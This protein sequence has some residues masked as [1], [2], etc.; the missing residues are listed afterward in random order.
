VTPDNKISRIQEL[1]YEIRIGE[2][3]KRNVITIGPKTHM[4]ELRGILRDKITR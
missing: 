4:S 2:V 3:M 1:V